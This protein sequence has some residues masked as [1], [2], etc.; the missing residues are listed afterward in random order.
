MFK[1]LH[2]SNFAKT[3]LIVAFL[4]LMAILFSLFLNSCGSN[5]DD[6]AATD[7]VG[8]NNSTDIPE[9]VKPNDS[10]TID[11]ITVDGR[12]YTLYLYDD[13]D[14]S[15]STPKTLKPENGGVVVLK[16]SKT[17]SV[18]PTLVKEGDTFL[19]WKAAKIDAGYIY[20]DDGRMYPRYYDGV[21]VEFEGEIKIKAEIEYY[22]DEYSGDSLFITPADEYQ[23]FF[24]MVYNESTDSTYI[25]RF[26]VAKN[27]N[28]DNYNEI[29]KNLDNKYGK[30]EC[31][32]TI[33]DYH[34]IRVPTD[35]FC[36]ATVV[37]MK[38]LSVIEYYE[39]ILED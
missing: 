14:P 1:T 21:T 23:E 20:L 32:M 22:T 30:Y 19:N 8:D 31:E 34:L 24:P 6:G 15:D 39:K 37:D 17:N 7:K 27:N 10:G 18:P 3:L 13:Y 36:V 35:R 2:K 33:K 4:V 38:D 9:V 29:L 25:T 26:T 5:P 28:K 12:K 11:N 16:A